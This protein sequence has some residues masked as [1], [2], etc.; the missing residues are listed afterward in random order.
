MVALSE[1][2]LLLS[3][4]FQH[5]FRGDGELGGP[6]F[7]NLFLAALTEVTGDF[8]EAVRLSSEILASKGHIFPA[9]VE[10]VRLVAE[11]K[12]GRVIY[13]ET[14]ISKYGNLIRRLRLEPET[15]H[16]L[17]DTLEAIRAAD[18]IT[19]GP[20]SL[21]TSLLP[22]LLVKGVSQEIADSSAAKVF[23]CN[24]MTQP[25][26]T[27][28]YSARKH[29]ETIKEYAPEIKFDYIIVNNHPISEEQA[30]R[31]TSEGAM[32]IGLHDSISPKTI[33]EAQIIYGN[34]LDHGEKVRHHP[35]KLAQVVLLC[36][37]DPYLS[38]KIEI[39]GAQISPLAN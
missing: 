36:G 35:D 20:G 3:K 6:S 39:D 34:L 9:T 37:Y 38:G 12:D 15:C 19:V 5:R 26:E 30:A 10:D 8:A 25:G 4:L 29:L 21:F 23:I 17:P 1:D 14:N 28:G 11:L 22:P 18:I 33:E 2:S 31:Y 27:D 7:G 13:G 24:L 16:P 32:Q